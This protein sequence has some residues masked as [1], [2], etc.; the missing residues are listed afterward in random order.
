MNQKI[1]KKFLYELHFQNYLLK[2]CIFEN[3]Q[4]FFLRVFNHFSQ[5]NI[6][7][8]STEIELKDEIDNILKIFLKDF[9]L[10]VDKNIESANELNKIAVG[11]N[12]EEYINHAFFNIISGYQTIDNSY[13]EDI[14]NDFMLC[15]YEKYNNMHHIYKSPAETRNFEISLRYFIRYYGFEFKQFF[16]NVKM[17]FNQLIS[18]NNFFTNNTID[19][20]NSND[21]RLSFN[22]LSEISEFTFETNLDYL[23]SFFG[24]Y[25]DIYKNDFFNT[26][27]N[28]CNINLKKFKYNHQSIKKV[29]C[30]TNDYLDEIIGKEN[31]VSKLKNDLFNAINIT[32]P[33][34]LINLLKKVLLDFDNIIE[35]NKILKSKFIGKRIVDLKFDLVNLNDLLRLEINSIFDDFVSENF[36]DVIDVKVINRLKNLKKQ[37]LKDEEIKMDES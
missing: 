21:F 2:N 37:G 30:I 33:S 17:T 32:Y 28:S 5:L 10:P 12:S 7:K 3:F 20:Q 29:S 1:S 27:Q 31:R 16:Y 15:I 36:P 25:N 35:T 34:N 11:L 9:V 22:N 19:F 18:I 26:Y 24:Y 4:N 14:F 8:N 6:T 13:T 23:V